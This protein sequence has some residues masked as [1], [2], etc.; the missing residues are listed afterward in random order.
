M[1]IK[2][3][4]DILNN[5]I[6]DEITGESA[7]VAEDLSNIVD[8]GAEI[9]SGDTING[10]SFDVVIGK[11]I[12]KIGKT[13]FHDRV[14]SP[15]TLGIMRDAFDYGSVLE[16]IR[17]DTGDYEENVSWDLQ[18]YT[19]DV[20]S[21]TAPD[22]SATYY[23]SKT[24]FTL[25]NSVTKNQFKSA[26]ESATAMNRFFAAIE[27]RIKTKAAIAT[28]SMAYRTLT[29]FIAEK[30]LRNSNVHNVLAEYYTENPS[31]TTTAAN[32]KA[33]REFL[34]FLKRRFDKI[35]GLI[36]KPSMKY[37]VD[38]YVTF[39]PDSK[40]KMYALDDLTSAMST[41]VYANA[42]NDEYVKLPNFRTVPFWQG[43]GTNDSY[44]SCS[45]II[46]IPASEGPAPAGEDT[47]DTVYQTGVI[48]VFVDEDALAICNDEPSTESIWNP[49]GRFYNWWFNFDCSYFN[50]INENGV[51]FIIDDYDLLTAEPADWVTDYE[52]YYTKEDGVYTAVTGDSAPT[53]AT[54]TYYKKIT[55]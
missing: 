26:F 28:E 19:P 35:R 15:D 45:S 43:A 55:A 39:T 40:L 36:R 48:A 23:N 8:V 32:W 11:I 21:Y 44:E 41:T 13:I 12:D 17:V 1:E 2:Q 42:F 6:Y 4:A 52:D 30:I 33:D 9:A 24:T 27:N 5:V 22:A 29:N 7:V 46:A 10:K 3:V 47:R 54:G 25:K 50:D 38:G 31:A 20:F 14:Y 37:N 18:N 53:F 49:E 16:K 34:A 51:V